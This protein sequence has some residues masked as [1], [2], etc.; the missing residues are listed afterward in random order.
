MEVKMGFKKR[1]QY[2]LIAAIVCLSILLGD[3]FVLSPMVNVWKK[4]AD[5]IASLKQSLEN[6]EI[7]VEREE[8][9]KKA[10]E[11]MKS[12]SLAAKT[13]SAENQALDSVNDWARTSG[14]NVTS[15]KPRWIQGDEEP[16][17]LELRLSA[18]GDMKSVARF[19]YELERDSLAFSVEDIEISTNNEQRNELAMNLRF[20]GLILADDES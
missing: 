15:L 4:R 13:S 3:K 7:L 1:E 11:D 18:K 5:R 19:L 16:K 12:R 9:L 10:W 6:G 14:L 2:L 20:T 8:A 17:K